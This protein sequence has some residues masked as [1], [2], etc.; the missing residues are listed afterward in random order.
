LPF[1]RYCEVPRF[2]F[3]IIDHE[4]CRDEEGAE[5]PDVDVACDR[6]IRAARDLAC[7]DV[8]EGRLPLG[9]RIEVED[10]RGEVVGA[11]SFADVIEIVPEPSSRS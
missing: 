2:F 5:L 9:N 10:E 4:V 8:R 3:H 6:A 7:Y 11:F 1:G